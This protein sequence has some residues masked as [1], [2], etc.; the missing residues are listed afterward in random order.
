MCK[1]VIDH[2]WPQAQQ[3]ELQSILRLTE[4]TEEGQNP[5]QPSFR[6]LV[7]DRGIPHALARY[8][9]VLFIL[10]ALPQPSTHAS[11]DAESLEPHSIDAATTK[12]GADSASVRNKGQADPDASSDSIT[13]HANAAKDTSATASGSN[14]LSEARASHSIVGLEGSTQQAGSAERQATAASRQEAALCEQGSQQWSKGIGMAGLPWALQL[15]AAFV[16]GHQVLQYA[17]AGST[18]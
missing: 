16:K 11:A 15:L 8:I 6:A 14:K 9:I 12:V 7:L 4:S 18:L 17:Y 13:S 10:P 1:D 5:D 3:S 2:T